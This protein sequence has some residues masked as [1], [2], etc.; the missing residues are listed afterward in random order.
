MYTI[1]TFVDSRNQIHQFEPSYFEA[2]AE[3]VFMAEDGAVAINPD[4]SV[5]LVAHI[6]NGAQS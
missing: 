3:Q 4:G 2:Q 5:N 6:D 1:L